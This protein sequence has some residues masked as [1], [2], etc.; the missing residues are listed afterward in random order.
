MDFAELVFSTVVEARAA[1]AAHHIAPT[2]HA[3]ICSSRPCAVTLEFCFVHLKP[4]L[5]V[6]VLHAITADAQ[7]FRWGPLGPWILS[8]IGAAHPCAPAAT[9]TAT[10]P[11]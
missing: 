11:R 4:K 7:R 3:A 1:T 2:K 8:G 9:A 10:A 6:F 5:D